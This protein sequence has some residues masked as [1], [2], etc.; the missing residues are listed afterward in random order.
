MLDTRVRCNLESTKSL[1]NHARCV[2]SYGLKPSGLDAAR[3]ASAFLVARATMSQR[4]VRAKRKITL[5]GIPLRVPPAGEF[6]ERLD[7]VLG[8]INAA[9]SE[10]WDDPAGLDPRA[11]G[12]AAEA[13]WLGRLVVAA[14]PNEPEAAGLLG[15]MLHAH[16]RRKARRD[17]R[18]AYVPLDRQDTTGW[19]GGMIDEAEQTRAASANPVGRFQVEAAIQSAHAVRRFQREPDWNAVLLLYDELLRLTNSLSLR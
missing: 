19:D 1:T 17:E 16:A 15:L 4:L 14:C 9:F 2:V 12:L 7:A 11:L 13:I 5:A 18:G 8:A 6:P 10:G 3:I